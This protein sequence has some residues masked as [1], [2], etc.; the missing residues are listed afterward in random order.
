MGDFVLPKDASI[1]LVFV[2]AGI[3]SSPYASIIKWL[4]GRGEQRAIQLIYSAG[5][6]DDFIFSEL[7]RQYPLEYVPVLTRPAS[8]WHGETGR[9]SVT[10]VLE[11]IGPMSNKLIYL[12]GPQSMIEP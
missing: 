5:Q 6:P 9:L 1:P 7:W 11:I 10:R 3:G 4:L 8:N 12:A 2:A